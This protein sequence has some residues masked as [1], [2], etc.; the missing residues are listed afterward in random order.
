MFCIYFNRWLLCKKEL[1]RN[2]FGGP[3]GKD[4]FT[5]ITEYNKILFPDSYSEM[6]DSYLLNHEQS[7]RNLVM[8]KH[9]INLYNKSDLNLNNIDTITESICEG[10]TIEKLLAEI[11]CEPESISEKTYCTCNITG[12]GSL[13]SK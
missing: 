8:K 9:M 10:K 3:S 1:Y 7:L 4:L 12:Q 13:T 6:E 5:K 11:K 2:I